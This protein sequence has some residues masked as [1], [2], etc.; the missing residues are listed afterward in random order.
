MEIGFVFTNYNNSNLTREAVRS[1]AL[2]PD[3]DRCHIVV[4]DNRSEQIDRDILIAL[5]EEY[6]EI[7][8]IYNEKNMGYFHGLNSGIAHLRETSPEIE[9]MV[10]GNN[11]LVFPDDF[12]VNISHNLQLFERFPVISPNILT[13]DGRHQNP[14]VVSRISRG[15]ELIWDLYYANYNF[16]RIILWLAKVTRRFTARKDQENYRFAQTIFMGYGACYLLG[17]VFFKFYTKLWAP[18][19][20][21]GEEFFLSKQ[22]ET[23]EFQICYEPSIVVHHHDHATT[24]NIP[25]R[26]FWDIS[27]ISH[28]VYRKYVNPYKLRMDTDLDSNEQLDFTKQSNK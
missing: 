7:Y 11:D 27:R 2:S 17:P 4:V 14:H 3:R 18:T 22:L 15:R 6:P 16:A 26:K 8:V 5:E 25:S 12:I 19:F 20:L 13:L 9:I 28:Q 1:L 23:K 21:M 24:D 10:I